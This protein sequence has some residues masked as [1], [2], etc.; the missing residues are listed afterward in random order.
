MCEH[1]NVPRRAKLPNYV[2]GGSGVD[3]RGRECVWVCACVRACVWVCVRACGCVFVRVVSGSGME[4]RAGISGDWRWNRL[5][6]KPKSTT[7]THTHS[8][9]LFHCVCVCEREKKERVIID[10]NKE[11]IE[12]KGRRR[13]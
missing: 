4:K 8:C 7:H 9:S 3:E 13:G 5:A 1:K 11:I 2:G 6:P 12:R 10:R